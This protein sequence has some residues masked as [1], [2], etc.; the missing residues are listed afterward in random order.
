[1]TATVT[2]DATPARVWAVLCDVT[3]YADWVE[4]TIEVLRG[5]ALDGVGSTYSERARLSGMLTSELEWTVVEFE[6]PT[7]LRMRGEGARA[8]RHLELEYRIDAA[9]EGS[10]VSSTYAYV[11]GFGVLGVLVQL[12]VRGNVVAD[13][14]RSLRTLAQVAEEGR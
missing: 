7:L 2:I 9:G 8:T 12:V 13:Q 10:E 3:R 6:P 11:P 5:D 1:M 4:N 14:C